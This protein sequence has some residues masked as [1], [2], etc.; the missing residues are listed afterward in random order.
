MY[1]CDSDFVSGLRLQA[2]GVAGFAFDRAG[3]IRCIN[4]KVVCA[5]ERPFVRSSLSVRSSA[6]A[7]GAISTCTVGVLADEFPPPPLEL[8]TIVKSRG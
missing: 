3:E 7:T 1:L 6:Q 8:L 4:G 2:E 5:R